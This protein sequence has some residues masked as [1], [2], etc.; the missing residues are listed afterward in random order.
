MTRLEIPN[1]WEFNCFGCSPTNDHGLQLKFY[2]SDKD[3]SCFSECIISDNFCGFNGL[4]HGGIIAAL[5]DEV[6]AWTIISQL[7]EVGITREI[8]TKFLNPVRANTKIRV[9]GEI[10]THDKKNVVVLSRITSNNGLLLAKAESNWIIPSASTL[11][12]IGGIDEK[13]VQ[14]LLESV[15]HPIQQLRKNNR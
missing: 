6:A 12:K 7:Y 1:L 10:I 2:L 14:Q 15:I 13:N 3:N 4:V 11:A 8:T 5:L 9:E